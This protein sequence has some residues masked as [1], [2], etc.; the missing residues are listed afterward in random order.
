MKDTTIL[1]VSYGLYIYKILCENFV[2]M[3]LWGWGS[4]LDCLKTHKQQ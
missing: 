2:Y 1:I 4:L 3:L